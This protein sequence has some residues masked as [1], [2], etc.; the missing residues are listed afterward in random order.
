MK[1]PI[2]VALFVLCS[3]SLG[4][5]SA[6]QHAHNRLAAIEPGYEE[7]QVLA[8]TNAQRMA[9]GCTVPLMLSAELGNA[10]EL[11]ALDLTRMGEAISHTGTDGSTMV[12]RVEAQ[13]YTG[14]ARLAENIAAGQ[15]TPEEVVDDWMASPGHRANIVNCSLREIGIGFVAAEGSVYGTYWAQNF[16]RR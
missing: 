3:M 13:G 12:S 7:Q 1:S 10:A 2:I 6:A 11:Y 8:L 4:H 16:G 14:W 9:N 15:L 5:A